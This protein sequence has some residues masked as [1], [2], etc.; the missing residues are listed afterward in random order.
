ME[1]TTCTLI[2]ERSKT[3]IIIA[4]GRNFYDYT[5]LSK[6]CSEIITDCNTEIICG[7]AKGADTLGEQYAKEHNFRVKYF[8]ADRGK[9]KKA[10]GFAR[11]IDMG[12]YAIKVKDS[13]LIAFWD[14]KSSETGHMISYAKKIGLKV[15]IFKY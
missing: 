2:E 6:K 12:D 9:L 4:G 3:R 13:I 10:A 15:Y 14:Y 11:N 8:P 5:L 1:I 7:M